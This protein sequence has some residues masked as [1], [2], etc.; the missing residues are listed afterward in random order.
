MVE[1]QS[2]RVQA[3]PT[4][5]AGPTSLTASTAA[6]MP[7]TSR[8]AK[9]HVAKACQN[10]KKAHLSCDEARPCARCVAAGKQVRPIH[11]TAFLRVHTFSFFDPRPSPSPF[12]AAI[13]Y[14]PPSFVRVC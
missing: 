4:A 8:R 12:R 9:A 11:E 1:S 3:A 10:C 13:T 7:K 5:Y 2:P 6:R 14:A